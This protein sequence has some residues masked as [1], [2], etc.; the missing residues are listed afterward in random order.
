MTI[1]IACALNATNAR[2]QV[3]AWRD[4]V[5]SGVEHCVRVSPTRSELTVRAGNESLNALADLAQL[6]TRCCPFFHFS[7]D[8]GAERVV[9]VIEV[10]DDAASVLASFVDEITA[11]IAG[12]SEASGR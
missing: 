11:G 4:V 1:P 2:A 10:P 12:P 8:V 5:T 3:R 6:E 7:F 9:L